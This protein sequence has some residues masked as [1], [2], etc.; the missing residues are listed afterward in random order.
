MSHPG[1]GVDRRLQVAVLSKATRSKYSEAVSGFAA[2]CEEQGDEADDEEALDDLVSEYFH[3][4]YDRGLGRSKAAATLYGMY[5]FDERLRGKLVLSER[6]LLGW[7]KLQPSKPYPPLSY[8]LAVLISVH[9]AWRQWGPL[10]V[11]TLLAFDCMLRIGELLA[12]VKEDVA[13]GGDVRVGGQFVD[14]VVVRLRRTKTG[15]EQ[16]SEVRSGAVKVLLRKLVL[17]TEDGQRLFPVSPSEYRRRFKLACRCLGLDAGYVPHSLR[18]GG[19]TWLHMQGVG[20]E[21]IMQMGRWAGSRSARRYIQSGRA[22]LLS[23]AVPERAA[24]AARVLAVA[25]LISISLALSH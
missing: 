25:P 19:A 23:V 13:V 7:S 1:G 6:A 24:E 10:A 8:D 16:W 18:H 17:A 2:W 9:L 11:G 3:C 12:I 4:L 14:R 21:D 15:K 5:G 22:L 20:L